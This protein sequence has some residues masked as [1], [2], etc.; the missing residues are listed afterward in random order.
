MNFLA[1][2]FLSGTDEELKIGNFI[3]DSVKGHDYEKFPGN[4]KKGILLH[5]AID[6]FT[7]KHP[8]FL[9]SR[10]RLDEKY[11]RH[12]G[13]LVD[14]FYDHFLLLNW[15]KYSAVPSGKYI[16]DTYLLLAA[17]WRILPPR[18]KR[19]LPFMIINNWLASYATIN[20]VKSVLERMSKRTSLPGETE[21]AIKILQENYQGFNNDFLELF[22]DLQ[23]FVQPK[24]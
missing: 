22:G 18:A 1:H 13:I 19:Y 7:D 8:A 20:G 9:R 3:G 4:I 17:N 21:F 14:I 2:L 15:E 12:S 16:R 11:S 6:D 24:L 10:K 5:R 23:L